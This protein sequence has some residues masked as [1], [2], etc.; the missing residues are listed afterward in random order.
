[1][2]SKLLAVTLATAI[3]ISSLSACATT[4]HAYEFSA[5]CH[6]TSHTMLSCNPGGKLMYMHKRGVNITNN[7]IDTKNGEKVKCEGKTWGVK[8]VSHHLGFLCIK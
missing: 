8:K 3:G 5:L 2:K 7:I 1:M 4:S 6:Y